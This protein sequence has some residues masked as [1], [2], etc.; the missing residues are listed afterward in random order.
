M[1]HV[2]HY[3]HD[4]IERWNNCYEVLWTIIHS[5]DLLVRFTGHGPFALSRCCRFIS[6]RRRSIRESD[7][8]ICIHYFA[9]ERGSRFSWIYIENVTLFLVDRSIVGVSAV[10]SEQHPF[11]KNINQS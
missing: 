6:E 4:R 7:I 11:G 5:T 1:T 8:I 10:L 3:H 2:Y 9:C